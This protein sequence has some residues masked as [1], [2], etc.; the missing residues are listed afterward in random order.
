MMTTVWVSASATSFACLCEPCLEE[1]RTAGDLF[2][3]ALAG[4]SVRGSLARD[5]QSAEVRCHAG[6]LIVLR[7]LERPPLLERP[8]D[9]QLQLT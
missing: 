8:D 5:S 4:A 1:A 3:D 6:H 9:R 7:R 2:A